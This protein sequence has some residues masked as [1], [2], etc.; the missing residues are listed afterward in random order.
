MSKNSAEF[1]WKI[2]NDNTMSLYDKVLKIMD[3]GFEYDVA[4][5][6]VLTWL[7]TKAA[8]DKD[9]EVLN[10]FEDNLDRRKKESDLYSD[11]LANDYK[12]LRDLENEDG[13][14]FDETKDSGD[15]NYCQEEIENSL[16]DM[17]DI[18]KVPEEFQENVMNMVNFNLGEVK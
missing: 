3:L 1:F 11:S 10:M 6:L 14:L 9:H 8:N 15:L 13:N 18:N 17:S 16:V 12:R 7:G 2:I 5:Y 4:Y